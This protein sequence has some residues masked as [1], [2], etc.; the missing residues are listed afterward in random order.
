MKMTE[1]E[2]RAWRAAMAYLNAKAEAEMA[3][4]CV[5]ATRA[6]LVGLAQHPKECGAGVSVT[7]YWKQGTPTWEAAKRRGLAA[8]HRLTLLNLGGWVGAEA[9]G[10]SSALVAVVEA[11]PVRAPPSRRAGDTGRLHHSGASDQHPV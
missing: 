9:E 3:D 7:R 8:T 11:P 5:D 4:A 6:A 2:Q 1:Q 10:L